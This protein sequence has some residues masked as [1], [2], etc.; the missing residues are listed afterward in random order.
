MRVALYARVST[1]E[2]S[3]HGLSIDAQLAALREWAKPH[4]VVDE[5]VDGGISARIP[6]KKRP[7]LQRLLR[8]VEAGRIDV[9]VFTKLDR[10]TRNIREYYKAQDVLDAHNVAWKA[11]HEDYETVTAAGRLKVNIMLA[12]AQDEADRTSERV[13]A[14][15][16]EKRKKG[17]AVNGRVPPGLSCTDGVISP[18]EDAPKVRELF[19]LYIAT[20]TLRTV[21]LA[22]KDILG[23]QY[24]NRGLKQLLTNDK[25][26]GT[27][28][29][30]DVYDAVQTIIETRA[31]RTV[32]SDRVYLFSG[33]VKCPVCGKKLTV[34]RN[35]WHGIEYIYY[36]CDYY[37][38]NHTCSW[39]GGIRE[40][41]LEDYLVKHIVSSVKGYNLRMERK[42]KK[43]VNVANIQK[44]LDKLT[45]LYLDDAISKEDYDSRSAP[46]RDAIKSAKSAPKPVNTQ[47]IVAALDVYPSLSKHAQKAFW[48]ALLRTVTPTDDGYIIDLI[49][50]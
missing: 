12:V 26:R 20:R 27:V 23:R 46:L 50:P 8:D 42:Q 33:I 25:Y 32:R 17:L 47:E 45:D 22:T 44:K 5:Y 11:I 2:Q 35:L 6:I 40:D 41:R 38:R 9:C 18:N 3:L 36:R 49:L 24:S 16:A 37:S 7:E 1:E 15:F 21:L 14:V 19:D 34:R 28:I 30:E 4:T 10:W 29:P 13:K 31:T 48:S 43:P 39:A